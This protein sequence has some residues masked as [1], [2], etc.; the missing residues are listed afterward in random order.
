MKKILTIIILTFSLNA[1]S[2]ISVGGNAGFRASRGADIELLIRKKNETYF[3]E[4]GIGT[5]LFFSK[6]YGTEAKLNAHI[7]FGNKVSRKNKKI[8]WVNE[9]S[10]INGLQQTIASDKMYSGAPVICYYATMGLILSTG[11]EY[12]LYSKNKLNIGSSFKFGIGKAFNLEKV[13]PDLNLDCPD[14]KLPTIERMS[15]GIVATYNLR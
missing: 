14:K 6:R 2:Q 11:I 7:L 12:K 5:I 15:L 9:I 1:F 10:F 8:F 13:R 4:A 3:L